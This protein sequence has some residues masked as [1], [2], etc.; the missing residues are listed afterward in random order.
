MK[1]QKTKK[2]IIYVEISYLDRKKGEKDAQNDLKSPLPGER[3]RKIIIIK[4]LVRM[5]KF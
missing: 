5:T 2:K 3:K 1:S 4:Y